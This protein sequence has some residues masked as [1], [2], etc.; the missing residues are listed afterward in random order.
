MSTAKPTGVLTAESRNYD[1][2][3][4]YDLK[5]KTETLTNWYTEEAML[6]V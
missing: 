4:H 2:E 3:G 6:N 1:I 5:E